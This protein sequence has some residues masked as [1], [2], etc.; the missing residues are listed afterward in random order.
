VLLSVFNCLTAAPGQK[1]LLG[2]RRRCLLGLGISLGDNW[3][4]APGFFC[5]FGSNLK[6]GNN[7][8]IGYHG[9]VYD[10]FSIEIGNGTVISNDLKLVSAT[11]DT[12]DISPRPGAITIGSDCWIGINVTIVGPAIIG[13]NTII[14]AGS[15]V[16]G[17]L[18]AN[19]ICAGVPAKPIKTRPEAGARLEGGDCK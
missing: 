5:L 16:L 9:H 8:V 12:K 11:H 14:G 3:Q 17:D 15:V 13:S 19:T 18:P 7:V 2:V 4:I 10:W 6:V 1:I